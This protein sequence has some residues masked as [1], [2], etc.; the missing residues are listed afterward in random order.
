MVCTPIGQFKNE[1]DFNLTEHCLKIKEEHESGGTEWIHSPYNTLTGYD[2]LSDSK[3]N[4]LYNWIA[5]CVNKFLKSV[6]TPLLNLILDGL[7]F[8]K[9]E[10]HKSFIII[11][12]VNFHVYII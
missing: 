4:E 6:V 1:K 12:E 8:M 10:I 11:G 3:F 7:M 2:I 9:K 5:K